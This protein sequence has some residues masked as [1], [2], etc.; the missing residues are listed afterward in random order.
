MK[1]REVPFYKNPDST[2]C[3]QATLRMVLKYFLP[4]KEF[5][6]TKL[7]ELTEKDDKY[8]TWTA[9]GVV[10][11][12]KMGFDVVV[13]DTFNPAAFAERG[14][15]YL[16]EFYGKEVAGG[17]IKETK[18]LAKARKMNRKYADLGVNQVQPAYFALMKRF[19]NQGYVLICHINSRALQK[20]EG[21]MGHFVVVYD[22]SG[23]NL[24]L[25]DPGP[26]HPK[27]GFKISHKN[28]L[29]PWGMY[30]KSDTR[31]FYA[32]KLN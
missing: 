10:N 15:K 9:M 12:K 16:I 6:W 21:Y 11:L 22:Y 5:S 14:A 26:K 4:N 30:S 18:N 28:F 24:I 25:H 31:N 7:D 27:K 2:H 19:I 20:K 3:Y 13:I 23:N 1:R 17:A 29:K 32:F 8:G